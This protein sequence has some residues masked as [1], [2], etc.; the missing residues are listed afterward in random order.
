LDFTLRSQTH[1]PP[2]QQNLTW[3][4]ATQSSLAWILLVTLA[5]VVVFSCVA[6]F[7]SPRPAPEIREIIALLI[8]PLTTLLGSVLG[9]YFGEQLGRAG[10]RL[11]PGSSSGRSRK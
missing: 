1:V 8:A 3:G 2:S 6:M 10:S 9:F 5:I 11:P 4:A 7:W